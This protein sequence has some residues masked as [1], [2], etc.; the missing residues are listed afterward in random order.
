MEKK[1]VSFWIHLGIVLV[2][3]ILLSTLT[4]LPLYAMEESRT[5][6]LNGTE[7]SNQLTVF[8][9]QRVSFGA[10][11]AYLAACLLDLPFG[12]LSTVVGALISGL[13]LGSFHY[14]IPMLLCYAGVFLLCKLAGLNKAKGWRSSLL[15]ALLCT[16]WTVL[17]YF[18]Y[19]MLALGLGYHIACVS[20]VSHMG[21]G[22][23]CAGVGL[24]MLRIKQTR[25]VEK[26][27]MYVSVKSFSHGD[28]A[29]SDETSDTLA[30]EMTAPS[31]EETPC[32]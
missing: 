10:M 29:H 2:A 19:D 1:P 9:Q 32:N 20:F 18:L 21:E 23:L 5:E 7:F 6:Y 25:M 31:T 28:K 22:L 4:S 14:L 3:I 8:S 11:G 16:G 15:V 13:V 30:E 17:V 12:L 24:L 26:G 27:E